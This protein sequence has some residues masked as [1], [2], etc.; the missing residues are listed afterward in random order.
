MKKL[1]SKII[2]CYILIVSSIFVGC[3]LSHKHYTDDFGVCNNCKKDI[4]VLIEKDTN[5][6][7]I[8]TELNLQ[9]HTDTYLKFVSNGENKLT[10][11]IECD[12]ADIKSIILYSKT[13]DYIASKYDKEDPVLVCNEQLTPNETYY[14]KIQSDKVASAKVI[15]Y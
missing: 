12:G 3:D 13:D 2:L 15:M 11:K 9:L 7:Y 4:S 14:I 8:E 10:I 1:L 5:N 6:N